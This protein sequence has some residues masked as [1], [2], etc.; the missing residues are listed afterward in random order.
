MKIRT[1]WT[2][3]RKFYKML[4][5]DHP[6]TLPIVVIGGIAK[7]I[8]PFLALFYS[9]RILDALLSGNRELAIS[10]IVTMLVA[11]LLLGCLERG[12]FHLLEVLSDSGAIDVWKRMSHKAYVVEFEEF[13]KTAVEVINGVKNA[14]NADEVLEW[15]EKYREL[16]IE[17]STAM[18]ISYIRYSCN[19]ADEFYVKEN[20]YF[21]EI[22]PQVGNLMNNYNDALLNS[23]FR[24]ELEENPKS[25][26]ASIQ[27]CRS[28]SVIEFA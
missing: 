6:T 13:E 23:P 10:Q 14:K 1:M 2:Y 19:T 15:R 25:A 8:G 20:D 27:S 5:K 4:H 11:V 26:K 17:Y 12:C 22:G 9:G 18:N 7:G 21:D 28:S 24:A 3:M 16:V